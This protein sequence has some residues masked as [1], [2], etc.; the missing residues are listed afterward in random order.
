MNQVRQTSLLAFRSL[1]TDKLNARQADVLEKIEDLFPVCDAQLAESL[2]WEINRVT[3]RRGELITK[4]KIVEAYIA[5][6]PNGR[7]V[8]YWKPSEIRGEYELADIT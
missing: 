6:G 5:V 7:K 8:T 1:T 4:K 2:G 3:P